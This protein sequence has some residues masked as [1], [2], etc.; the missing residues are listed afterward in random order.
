MQTEKLRKI[1]IAAISEDEATG[2]FCAVIEFRNLNGTIG[3]LTLPK[4]KLRRP[5]ELLATLDDAGARLPSADK[6]AMKLMKLLRSAGEAAPRWKYAP[7]TGWYKGHRAFSH[8]ARI[9]GK[10]RGEFELRPPRIGPETYNR[11]LVFRGSHKDWVRGVALPAKYSSAM[12]FA[13]CAA[14][15][16]PLLA[17]AKVNS[18]GIHLWGSSKCA[19]SSALLAAASV[20]GFTTEQDLLNFRTTD[21]AFGEIVGACNDMLAPINEL[22][23]KKGSAAER[24][25]WI[26]EASYLLG[27]GR[28]T[29]YSKIAG[30]DQRLS[31]LTSRSIVLST[32]EESMDDI[33][34]AAGEMR[35]SGAALRWFDLR[36][37][38]EDDDDIFDL[39]KAG[40][41]SARRTWVAE[42]CKM[43]RD[44]CCANAGVS[45][46][47]FID[48]AI[49]A[50][51]R[52]AGD[53][54]G[55]IDDFVR[56]ESRDGEDLVVGHLAMCCGLIAGA[57]ILAIRFQTLP[58]SEEL[59]WKCVGRCFR[60][61]KRGL[62][63]EAVLLQN[64]LA[65]LRKK[66]SAEPV[67]DLKAT[68]QPSEA[69]W[70]RCD[71]YIKGS[72]AI[73]RAERFKGWFQD[74]R[75]LML[76]LRWLHSK[77]VLTTKTMPPRAI[78]S[79]IVWAESRPKWPNGNRPRSIVMDLHAGVIERI[80]R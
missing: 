11:K 42:Q 61:A 22:G 48:H 78:K 51:R 53:L 8:P 16:A 65:T 46:A 21:A 75:E 77:G 41:G 36:A 58:W 18:F 52:M 9:I 34:S 37:T 47:H 72:C 14:L 56:R 76:V 12:V 49:A 67:I 30:I 59:V 55:L 32:G 31:G 17:F 13:I 69:R 38:R 35:M 26:R 68:A 33:Y 29:T 20:M 54:Q 66:L 1:K 80:K 27:E 45:F 24:C 79:K 43:L 5:G 4:S 50:R 63:T 64:G 62:R 28:G 19:K 10:P 2:E 60:R 3:Q 7:R 15:A 25:Q 23:L 44:A 6:A 40:A 73:V 39:Y 71:G 74:R 70:K 57:G